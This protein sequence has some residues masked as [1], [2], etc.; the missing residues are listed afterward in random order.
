MR[1]FIKVE[2]GMPINHPASEDNLF[3][4]LGEIPLDWEP[5]VRETRPTVGV[6]QILESEETT[7]QKVNGIWTDVWAL[8]DMTGDE[9][10]AK[11]NAKKEWWAINQKNRSTWIFNET[12]CDFDPPVQY[13]TDG[14]VYFWQGISNSWVVEPPHPMDGQ[15]WVLNNPTATWILNPT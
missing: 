12:T 10:L 11:Q 14:Q 1:L 15:D 2:N 13:P 5:F 8:R 7:Y 4:S 9:K 3:Q 6:Y